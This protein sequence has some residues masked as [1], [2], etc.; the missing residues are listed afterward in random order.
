MQK[1]IIELGALGLG[2]FHLS[3]VEFRKAFPYLLSF[4]ISES[5]KLRQY[6]FY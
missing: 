3:P 1:K 2:A 5:Q 6:V 4:S